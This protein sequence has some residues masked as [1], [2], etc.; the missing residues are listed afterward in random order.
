MLV[1]LAEAT[2]AECG[3]KAGALG[4]LLRAGVPVP[5][6]FVITGEVTPDDVS[7]GLQRLGDAPVAVRSSA[8]GEDTDAASAA[9]QYESF[10][11]VH[12]VEAVCTAVDDC[13]ASARSDRVKS[14]LTSAGI[15]AGEMAV[16]VQT[17]VPAEVSGVMFTPTGSGDRTRIE[18]ARGLGIGV[19]G[20]TVTPDSYLVDVDGAVAFTAGRASTRIDLDPNGG[21]ITTD[22]PE[23]QTLDDGPSTRLAGSVDGSPNCGSPLRTSSGR[24]PATR[25]GFCRPDRSPRRCP[26]RRPRRTSTAV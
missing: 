17:V 6:G 20:G 24:S 12:G 15:E 2:V 26:R 18:A 25:S 21:V 5:N 13:R 14:Y 11:G 7:Q 1:D 16:L 8:A 3:G 22:V 9:G 10:L 19:V 23:R 4:E